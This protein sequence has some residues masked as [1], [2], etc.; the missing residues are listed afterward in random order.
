M[1]KSFASA[2]PYRTD[3]ATT[4]IMPLPD[5]TYKA[6]D[7]SSRVVSALWP[8]PFPDLHPGELS[9]VIINEYTPSMR[10][11]VAYPNKFR[12]AVVSPKTADES[13]G[14]HVQSFE[15][16]LEGLPPCSSGTHSEEEIA[17]LGQYWNQ[18]MGFVGSCEA[19]EI[20]ELLPTA[21]KHM[22]EM[23]KSRVWQNTTRMWDQ[24]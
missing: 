24:L 20:D 6:C 5:V 10:T 22:E 7:M 23:R 16:Y 12:L 1:A 21:A 13:D 11:E 17:T 4:I 19:A 8:V 9:I 3:D 15:S 14:Y 2:S 18:R